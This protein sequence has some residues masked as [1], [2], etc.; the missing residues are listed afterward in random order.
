MTGRPPRGPRRGC[1]RRLPGLAGAFVAALVLLVGPA[2]LAQD[3]E[4][5]QLIIRSVDATDSDAIEVGLVWNGE[6]SALED[7]TIRENG[8]ERDHEPVVPLSKTGVETG[9]VVAVD[10]SRS[11]AR[12]GGVA[13]TQKTLLAMVDELEGNEAMGLVTFG[14]TVKELSPL[15]T[16]KAELRKAIDEIVAPSNADTSLWDGVVKAASMFPA[17]SDL[18]PNIVLITDG[19]NDSSEATAGRAAAE[20]KRAEAAVFALAYDAQNHVDSEA[21][22]SLVAATG[23]L[24]IPAPDRADLAAGLEEVTTSLSNQY[25]VTYAGQGKQG[26]VELELS[27]G[28]ESAT[29]VFVTGDKV[30]GAGNVAPPTASDPLLPSFVSGTVGLIVVVAVGGLAVAL[31]VFAVA[32]MV[33]KDETN[34]DQMLQQ[35]TEPGAAVDEEGDTGLAQTAFVQRA[36]DFTEEV[37]TKQGVLVKV[38]RKLEQADLPLRAAEG[39]FF[40]IVG[41]SIVTVIGGVLMGL[42]GLLIFGLAGFIL[43]MAVLNFLGRRRQ[44][45]FDSQLPDML[46]LLAGSLRAGYSLVQGVDAVSKEVDGPM[47]RELRRIMTEAQLGR[48]LEDAFEMAAAR[49]QSKDFE[50]AIMAIRIQRE[51]GGN[52]SELLMTVADTMVER[53]RLRRD[54]ATLTAEGKISA[55]ILGVMPI[56]LG[57]FMSVSNPSYMEP[58]FS[59]GL[60]YILIGAAVVMMAIGFAWMKKCITIEI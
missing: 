6:R 56:G 26:A 60:G 49:V 35:Y 15:T 9:L 19:Y 2:A 34:L 7:L 39:L 42:V 48:E 5:S 43:P 40:Y 11:M 46:S 29:S 12:N 13:E 27:V 25:V 45:Q 37:A 50:W 52:L 28:G 10:T 33:S 58:L 31:A 53:E 55:I 18:Q 1:S 16:D 14:S 59:P 32:S 57:A 24:V 21:I 4:A 47:G 44:K 36:V 30:A 51:V 17:S 54:V 38:E 23:G 20:V 22:G 41:A 3:G 8:Q